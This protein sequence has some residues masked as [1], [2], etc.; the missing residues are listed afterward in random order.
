[1]VALVTGASR[2]VGRG[3]ALALSD[4]GATVYA[5]GRT[6]AAAD[7]DSRIVRLPCD[8][9]DDDAVANVFRQIDQT[10]GRLD[11]L[12]NV[13]WGGYERM[14]EDGRFTW[15]A[16]VWEQPAWRWDAMVTAGVRA[17]FVASQHAARRM[18]P[19]R[20]GLIVHIS[21]WAGQKYGGNVMY[22]V[23]KAATD[24]MAADMAVVLEP[25][26]G[27]VELGCQGS[28]RVRATVPGV[29]AHPARSWRGENAIHRAGPERTVT[30]VSAA[31]LLDGTL[32]SYDGLALVAL[33]VPYT[34]NLLIAQKKVHCPITHCPVAFCGDGHCP[35]N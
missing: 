10:A 13:A 34:V 35:L 32:S 27:V 2:G 29:R 24:K 6:I 12:A 30:V 14:V 22:G 11:I 5:T 26:N 21:S 15:A 31:L 17:A 23:A 9:T 18:V 28:V 8:H 1:M 4:A 20:R 33:F 16:P 19:A 25:T 3:I 7:L